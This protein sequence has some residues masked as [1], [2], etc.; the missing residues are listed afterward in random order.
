[1]AKDK[2]LG[3]TQSALV[4]ASTAIGGEESGSASDIELFMLNLRRKETE[5]LASEDRIS[6]AKK[7]LEETRFEE[8]RKRME[9][10]C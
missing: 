10:E 4:N 8:E 1:M 6:K 7:H 3:T 5:Q 9:E 2:S